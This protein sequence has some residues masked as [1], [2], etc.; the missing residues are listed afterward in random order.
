M[1]EVGKF[2]LKKGVLMSCPAIHPIILCQRRHRGPKC[3]FKGST[4]PCFNITKYFWV[5]KNLQI[6][7][8]Y[9][10]RYSSRDSINAAPAEWKTIK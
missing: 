1:F 10:D 5:Q 3:F 8:K 2:P 9:F 7:G 4:L 6:V